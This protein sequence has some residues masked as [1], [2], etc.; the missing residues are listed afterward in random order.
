MA[1]FFS[2]RPIVSSP[3]PAASGFSQPQVNPEQ[4]R[5]QG[6]AQAFAQGHWVVAFPWGANARELTKNGQVTKH[7]LMTQKG[8][9]GYSSTGNVFGVIRA[10]GF[11]VWK[12]ALGAD[13]SPNV[14]GGSWQLPT[15]HRKGD[16][17]LDAL[18]PGAKTQ[19][20][21]AL[22]IGAW[23]GAM[24]KL[25]AELEAEGE[26]IEAKQ[27]LDK[28]NSFSV[29]DAFGKEIN[30]NL[31]IGVPQ[32]QEMKAQAQ[33]A[34]AAEGINRKTSKMTFNCILAVTF[35]LDADGEFKM[36]V[37]NII[38]AYAP[39]QTIPSG[40]F[41]LLGQDEIMTALMGGD[42]AFESKEDKV[43]RLTARAEAIA[44]NSGKAAKKRKDG[45]AIKALAAQVSCE[46]EVLKA[47][48]VKLGGHLGA[49]EG[50]RKHGNDI[51]FLKAYIAKGEGT[52]AT[53]S[54]DASVTAGAEAEAS[55]STVAEPPTSMFSGGDDGE[56]DASDIDVMM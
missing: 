35:G 30:F 32:L 24:K 5:M 34:A 13:N 50:L 56:V 25:A 21:H 2:N 29:A 9:I 19:G 22:I 7:L 51:A 27:V 37:V 52:S 43:A 14:M 31:P 28:A 15:S 3:S 17:G 45:Q 39:V 40:E 36:R 48:L 23:K 4:A 20:M 38:D 18:V 46:Y 11:L 53:P 1:N 33:A 6:I 55:A 47:A 41:Q 8:P 26:S 54:P 16:D 10:E 42:E 12:P 49:P 44:S